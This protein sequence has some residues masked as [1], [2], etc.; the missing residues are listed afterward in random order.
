M[1]LS[2][3]LFSAV[4]AS[5]LLLTGCAAENETVVE[6]TIIDEDL[7]AVDTEYDWDLFQSGGD[8]FVIID[9]ETGGVS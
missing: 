1:M 3:K 5:V 9:L 4:T 6:E 8:Q 7:W 2:L